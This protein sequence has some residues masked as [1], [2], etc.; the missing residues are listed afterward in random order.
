MRL[1][2]WLKKRLEGEKKPLTSEEAAKIEIHLFINRRKM[3][4]DP[5][6]GLKRGKY[7]G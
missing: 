6:T 5:K 4:L 2:I 7:N 1:L 3:G